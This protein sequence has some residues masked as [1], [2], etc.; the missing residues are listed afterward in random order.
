[1]AY[2]AVVI[3]TL[4]ILALLLYFKKGFVKVLYPQISTVF[5]SENFFSLDPDADKL[6]S[7]CKKGKM[8]SCHDLAVLAEQQKYPDIA[9]KYY[10]KACDAKHDP[11]CQAIKLNEM[12]IEAKIDHHIDQCKKQKI[13]ES[14][15][16]LGEYYKNDNNKE[17]SAMY[18][19]EGCDLKNKSSCKKLEV[20]L[21]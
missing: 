17:F 18:L 15:H 16:W 20:H 1:M 13:G 9:S 21:H 11:S 19:Q 7:E 8:E 5:D 3:P 10:K 14:C 2:K 6:L 4:I 12:G